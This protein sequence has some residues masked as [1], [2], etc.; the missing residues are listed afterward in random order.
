MIWMDGEDRLV[1]IGEGIRCTRGPRRV[2]LR[3]FIIFA[4]NSETALGSSPNMFHHAAHKSYASPNVLLTPV[5]RWAR[6]HFSAT[7]RA[8]LSP[9]TSHSRLNSHRQKNRDFKFSDPENVEV[10]IHAHRR[11]LSAIYLQDPLFAT[12]PISDDM[13]FSKITGSPSRDKLPSFWT[14]P[15]ARSFRSASLTI[16]AHRR[17]TRLAKLPRTRSIGG[18]RVI[19]CFTILVIM[20][21]DAMQ[22]ICVLQQLIQTQLSDRPV[23]VISMKR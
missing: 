1:M 7:P 11:R 20:L 13:P 23:T 3:F 4:A 21:K 16:P 19:I 9:I 5:S 6:R 18:M 8:G 22:P 14:Y 12:P 10:D 15:R 17:L 2:I